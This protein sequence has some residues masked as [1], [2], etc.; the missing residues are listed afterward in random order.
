MGVNTTTSGITC[1]AWAST[2]P[3]K[4]NM[5]I[6]GVSKLPENHCRNPDKHAG[7]PWCYTTDKKRDGSIVRFPFVLLLLLQMKMNRI[8][9]KPI[10]AAENDHPATYLK[11]V[12]S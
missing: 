4:P 11:F 9:S 8:C 7:G 12:L 6:K 1:Q 3:H 2:T 10:E 5:K